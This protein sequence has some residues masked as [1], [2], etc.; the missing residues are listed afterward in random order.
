MQHNIEQNRVMR[1]SETIGTAVSF[2]SE[3][4][5][6]R[7]RVPLALLELVLNGELE[8]DDVPG[9]DV[10]F[11]TLLSHWMASAGYLDADAVDAE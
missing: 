11:R 3:A 1:M 9:R 2:T 5:R 4:T 7:V 8:V 10:V 6:Q